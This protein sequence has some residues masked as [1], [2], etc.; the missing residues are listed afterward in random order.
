MLSH[1]KPTV[2]LDTGR[3]TMLGMDRTDGIEIR[4]TTPDEYRIAGATVARALMHAPMNDEAWNKPGHFASWEGSDSLS[5]WEG[6][7]CVGNAG[8]YR[9]ETLVPGGAW[10]PTCGVTR[11]GVLSTHRR[12]GLLRSMLSRL[13]ADAAGRGQVLASLRASETRI[14]QRFGFGLAG[15]TAEA[16]LTSVDALP[17]TGVDI[18]GSM[19]MLDHDEILPTVAD[20]YERVARRP[21][22]IA[23]P[24]WIWQRY[25]EKALELGGDG[26]FVAVHTSADG[27]DDGFVHYQVKWVEARSTPP[28]GT[29]EVYDLWGVT[30]GVELALWD[31]LCNVDLVDEWYAEERPVDDVIQ[32]AVADTRAFRTKWIVDEQW[33]RVVDVDAALTLRRFADVDGALTIGVSDPLLAQN[34]GVWS[35]SAAGGKRVGDDADPDLSVD[36][37]QL[38]AAYLGGT[39]WRSLVGA[40]RVHVRNQAAVAIADDL[41]A[42]AEA[43][44]CCTGF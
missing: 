44:Y 16:T 27:V 17:L 2:G 41:F 39:P 31:Y 5:A 9:F 26:E 20:I 18:T 35:V 42:V 11:V 13:L 23:R 8:G 38:S 32:F 21:G 34:T 22:V 29:G 14:Y 28:R 12:R 19:R 6:G 1:G 36:I 43:P 37:G 30:P 40:G 7:R 24:E 25:L 4:P 10:L 33:L 3:A 15:R